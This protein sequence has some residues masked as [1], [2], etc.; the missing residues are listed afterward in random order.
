MS[1]KLVAAIALSMA[2]TACSLMSPDAKS[3]VSSAQ[4]AMGSPKSIQYSGTGMNAFFG[5]ALSAGKEWPRR[6]MTSY[7]R[8]INYDQKAASDDMTFAQPV[9]GGQHQVTLVSGDKAWNMG[10]N[11]PAP[12]MAQA[13]ARQLQIWLSPHGFLKGAA[14]APDA[15]LKQGDGGLKMVSFKALGK[16]TVTGTIDGQDMVTKVETMVADSVLGDMPVVTNYSDYKDFNGVKFPTKILQT[17]DGFAVWDVTINNVQPNAAADLAV[18]EPVQSA[19]I[20]PGKS[21]NHE[22][23]RWSL[24]PVRRIPSQP[25]AGFQRLHRGGGGTVERGALD[26]SPGGGEEAG[27]RQAGEV[28]DQHASPLRSF[29]WLAHVRGGGRDHRYARVQQ[30][31]FRENV[32]GTRDPGSGHAGEKFETGHHRGCDGQVG[33]DQRQEIARGLCHAGRHPH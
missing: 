32:P 27:P 2:M 16:Y 7:T 14:D 29:G 24:V 18:P 15:T 11:G 33:G 5:Q 9:F 13:E 1:T 26:G 23:G 28:F 6:D 17:Q 20:P 21:G 12:Q 3:V 10:P 31:V 22:D 4:K 30:G 19:S 25:G 8:T